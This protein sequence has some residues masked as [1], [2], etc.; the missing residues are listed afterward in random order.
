MSADVD[1]AAS[2]WRL[3]VPRRRLAGRYGDRAGRGIGSS[4]EFEEHRAYQ[5]GDDPRHVATQEHLPLTVERE[6]T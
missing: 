6:H 1:R 4:I 5:P 2:R 3:A